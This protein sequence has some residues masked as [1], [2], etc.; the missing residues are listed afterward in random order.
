MAKKTTLSIIS[1]AKKKSKGGKQNQRGAGKH[2]V[3]LGKRIRLRRVEINI[4]Q[5]EL[6]D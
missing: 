2:D 4:S 3:E 5:S 1:N 6:A